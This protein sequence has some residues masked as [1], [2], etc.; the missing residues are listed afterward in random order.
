MC[1]RDRPESVLAA[2]GSVIP[3]TD[4]NQLDDTINMDNLFQVGLTFY[5]CYLY[6]SAA[7]SNTYDA[8]RAA[9]MLGNYKAF[10]AG[11]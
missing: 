4:L 1:I 7:G 3:S 11:G 2:D 8:T 10:F 5:V 6:F 9:E